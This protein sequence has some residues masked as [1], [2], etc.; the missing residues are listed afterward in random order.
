MRRLLLTLIAVVA[1]AALARPAEAQLRFGVQGALQTAVDDL[2]DLDADNP[3]LNG[4]AGLGAR[5]ALQPPLLPAGL[6]AQGV[7]YFPDCTD[8]SY[9]TYSLA[10]QL[11]LTTPLVSP[12]AIAGW[13]WRRS[14]V[15]GASETE[16]GAMLGVGAQLNVAVA[17]FLEIMFEF[18]DEIVPDF[19]NDPVVIK[20]GVLFG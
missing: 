9:L 18:H 6:V 13:Q 2:R 5:V 7:Y 10:A 12:Y 19:D 15:M 14:E 11:R 1:T 16:N 8:C 20:L 17:V 3:D 4:T